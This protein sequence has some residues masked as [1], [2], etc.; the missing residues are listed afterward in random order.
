MFLFNLSGLSRF[1]VSLLLANNSTSMICHGLK[2]A[3]TGSPPNRFSKGENPG[4]YEKAKYFKLENVSG[5]IFFLITGNSSRSKA[6][7]KYWF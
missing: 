5:E 1:E 3:F 6:K 4:G 7:T 2:P